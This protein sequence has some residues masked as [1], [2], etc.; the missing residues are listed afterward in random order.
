MTGH[1]A[2]RT[3]YPVLDLSLF[4][5]QSLMNKA[6]FGSQS[7][8]NKAS[9]Q[10][11]KLLVAWRIDHPLSLEPI[12]ALVEIT[13]IVLPRVPRKPALKV[14]KSDKPVDISRKGT[15]SAAQRKRAGWRR[16]AGHASISA[17]GSGRDRK[18]KSRPTRSAVG[19]K[20][21]KPGSFGSTLTEGESLNSADASADAGADWLPSCGR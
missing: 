3:T 5:S 10:T 11:S 17:R 16:T 15:R 1:E 6:L 9:T 14:E 13:L 18:P 19:T 20:N 8:M 2:Q 21:P 7:L 4:G 12:R